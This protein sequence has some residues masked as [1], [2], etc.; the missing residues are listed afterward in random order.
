MWDTTP[1]TLGMIYLDSLSLVV[2]GLRLPQGRY[3]KHLRTGHCKHLSQTF[4]H[5]RKPTN[6][7][8]PL[9]SYKSPP[10]FSFNSFT[11]LE[12][13]SGKPAMYQ[14]RLLWLFKSR[15]YLRKVTFSSNPAQNSSGLPSVVC[16]LDYSVSWWSWILSRHESTCTGLKTKTKTKTQKNKDKKNKKIKNFE[17]PIPKK[18][19][20]IGERYATPKP[21]TDSEWW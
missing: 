21:L 14:Q 12:T 6:Q 10:Y 17:Q 9:K 16:A 13:E 4:F 7:H 15:K 8:I 11:K 1:L 3:L 19:T 20:S 18:S 2:S 5:P